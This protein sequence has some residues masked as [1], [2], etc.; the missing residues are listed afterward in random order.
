[1]IDGNYHPSQ[2]GGQTHDRE[3]QD[4]AAFVGQDGEQNEVGGNAH[5]D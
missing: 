5:D 2:K 3:S 1:M 4:V